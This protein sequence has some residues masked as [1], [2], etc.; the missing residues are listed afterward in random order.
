MPRVLIAASGTGGHLFPAVAVAEQ[1][2]S[3]WKIIWLGVPDRL[4]TKVLLGKYDLVTVRAGGL[5]A[6]GLRKLFQLW[7]LLAATKKVISLHR[8]QQINVVYRKNDNEPCFC[9]CLFTQFVQ[10]KNFDWM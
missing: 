5:Q 7:Q 8:E 9:I 6:R 2:S 3:A 1:F 10:K 4:E